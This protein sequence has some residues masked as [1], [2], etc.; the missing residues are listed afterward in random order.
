MTEK[1]T[2]KAFTVTANLTVR[3]T[4]SASG[5]ALTTIPN[6]M[7]IKSGER[8]NGWYK[9]TFNGKTGWVSGKYLTAY[10][11]PTTTTPPPTPAKPKPDPKPEPKP[12][13]TKDAVSVAKQVFGSGYTISGS[14]NSVTVSGNGVYGGTGK[15]F[16]GIDSGDQGS[17]SKFARI[18][19]E[20]NGGD[21][22]TLANYM[23]NARPGQKY[24]NGVSYGKYYIVASA[25][26][27]VSVSW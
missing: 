9:V 22:S 10:K 1:F 20:L 13:P 24:W 6:G 3:S 8:Y 17:Y 7:V 2:A 25:S 23:W 27:G 4:Y 26:G 18:V 12:T 19:T 11:A 16:L 21:S 5:K 14:G 15:G